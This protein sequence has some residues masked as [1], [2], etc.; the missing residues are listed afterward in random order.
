MAVIGLEGM[1]FNGPHGFYP[2][3][4]LLGNDFVVDVYVATSTR[5]AAISDD[6]GATV[7]YET[8]YLMVQSE[9]RK[10]VQLIE[11]L[12][13]RILQRLSSFYESAQGFRVIVRKLHPPLG[14]QVDAAYIEVTSGIFQP[15]T[16]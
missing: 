14:G 3:E 12:A 16:R 8:V 13:E 2:E 9:M 6:L 5:R 11:T 4:G 15:K 10:P 7:N 1:R